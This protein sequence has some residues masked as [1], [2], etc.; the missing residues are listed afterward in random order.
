MGKKQKNCDPANP[1]D[2]HRGDYWDHIAIDAEHKLVLAVIPG[3]RS[4]ENACAIVAD[5]RW[6]YCD[7]RHG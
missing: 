1:D 2:D 3:A 5:V 4:A 7:R 6:H